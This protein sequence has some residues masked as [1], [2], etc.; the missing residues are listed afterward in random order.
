M[1][2]DFRDFRNSVALVHSAKGSE[3]EKHKYVAKFDGVYF[4]PNGYDK[5]RTLNSLKKFKRKAKSAKLND[6]I[7]KSK[8]RSAKLTDTKDSTKKKTDSKKEA[9]TKKKINKIAKQVIA[10]KYGVG[11]ER[12]SKLGKKYDR[13]QNRVNTIL[14]GK[15]GAKKVLEKKQKA[16]LTTYGLKSSKSSSSKSSSTKKKKTSSS[17]SSSKK[18][19]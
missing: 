3:W 9:K 5:G 1:Y 15:A 2:P 10:G 6:S 18:K 13:V 16:G 4:Y 12:M 11:S 19:K 14:L 8:E 17:T 7:A